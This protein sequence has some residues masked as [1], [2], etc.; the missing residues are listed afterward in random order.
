MPRTRRFE[1]GLRLAGLALAGLGLAGLCLGAFSASVRAGSGTFD[2]DHWRRVFA[3]PEYAP[4]PTGNATT[5]EKV[6]LGAM[7]FEDPR[8]SGDGT[9]SCATCHQAELSFT[10]GVPRHEGHDGQPLD[11]RTP[12]LWNTAWGLSWFWDGRAA[13]L[14]AQAAEPIL[15][16]REMAG[17]VRRAVEILAADAS[18]SRSFARAFPEDPTVTRDNILKALAAFQRTLVSPETKFDR[19]VKGNDDALDQDEMAGFRLFVGRARCVS[20]HTGWR[21]TD[22]AFHDIGLPGTDPGRGA[23]LG[24]K[25]VDNAFKTPSLRERVWTAPYTH[26][27][28]LTTLED[29]VDHYA[30]RVIERPTVS[31]DLPRRIEL[32]ATERAQL[33]AFL[34][35]L[36]S[37]DPPRPASLP[38]RT[39]ALGGDAQAATTFVGQKNR[40]FTPGAVLLKVGEVL[41]IV[42]DDTRVHNV[43]IDGPGMSVNSDAQNPGDTVT[44]GFDQPGRYDAICGVHP[45]MRLTVQVEP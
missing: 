8:L 3:R 12:S 14:E 34:S 20:C 21:F 6:A 24:L 33:V 26:D 32:N 37:E 1:P 29:V 40:R 4:M 25:E 5:P 38:A 31:A 2:A 35:T 39:I 15:N 27:G 44:V 19:W 45:E 10:D 16:K 11:R 30:D 43:R 28:S 18:A 7:L 41:R 13:G 17:D 9:V 23:V 42:N 22:E 36:S